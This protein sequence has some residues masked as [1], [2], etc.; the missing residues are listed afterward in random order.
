MRERKGGPPLAV[1]PQEISKARPVDPERLLRPGSKT[2]A[3]REMPL[4]A[5]LVAGVVAALMG[6][7]EP[8]VTLRIGY[9]PNI[10]V[11]SAFLG[12]LVI[13]LIGRLSPLRATRR[14]TNLI[15]TAGTAAGAGVVFLPLDL[16][17]LDTL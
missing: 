2:E 5:V 15:Q 9:G 7:A 17:A 3:R 11:V 13:G 1:E 8:M 14:D 4:R 12:F 16:A 6:A 10:S